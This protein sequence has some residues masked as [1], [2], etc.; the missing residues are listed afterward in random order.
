MFNS[1]NGSVTK[2]SFPTA[3]ACISFVLLSSLVKQALQIL[4]TLPRSASVENRDNGEI[5]VHT[6]GTDASIVPP[7]ILWVGGAINC[8]QSYS[9]KNI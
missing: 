8:L 1:I 3:S 4:E 5:S 9:L 7:S 2:P 6:T